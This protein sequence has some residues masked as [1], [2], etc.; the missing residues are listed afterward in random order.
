M[1][2]SRVTRR[3]RRGYRM[4][5]HAAMYCAHRLDFGSANLIAEQ[6]YYH[7]LRNAQ[8]RVV[9]HGW[10]TFIWGGYPA[11]THNGGAP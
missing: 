2:E 3:I 8:G 5:R 6:W 1:T 4:A 10:A 9:I 7:T 11:P